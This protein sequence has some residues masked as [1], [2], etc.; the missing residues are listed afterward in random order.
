MLLPGQAKP[1]AGQLIQRSEFPKNEVGDEFKNFVN[2]GGTGPENRFAC[3]APTGGI[4]PASKFPPS[5]R[6]KS[7]LDWNNEVGIPPEK[8]FSPRLNLDSSVKLPKVDGIEPFNKLFPKLGGI[9][10]VKLLPLRSKNRRFCFSTKYGRPPVSHEQGV[11]SEAFQLWVMSE[12]IEVQC[13]V[14]ESRAAPSEFK[15]KAA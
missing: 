14:S 8:L 10:P 4:S 15:A 3:N 2:E 1:S 6:S 12:G 13:L 9:G 5:C 11:E 7:L